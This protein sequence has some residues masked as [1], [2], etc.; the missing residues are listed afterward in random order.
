MSARLLR[1]I[2]VFAFCFSSGALAVAAESPH[3][4]RSLKQGSAASS[5][6]ADARETLPR[7]SRSKKNSVRTLAADRDPYADPAAP[8]K[9]DRLASPGA[10]PILNIPGATVLTREVL[11]DMNATT[12]RD[13]LRATP[14]VT[15]GR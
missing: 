13:G 2:A 11:D 10:E 4:A 8:Y 5:R 3:H 6:S 7:P 14:G 9:A 12:L 15:V 1:M